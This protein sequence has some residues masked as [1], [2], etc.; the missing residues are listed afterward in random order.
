MYRKIIK[1]IKAQPRWRLIVAGLALAG[2]VVFLSRGSKA[3]ADMATFE[4]RR[5]ALQISVLEGGTLQ[6]LSS[7]E[8]K[9]EVRVGYQGTKIL[10][11]VDEGY[12]VTEEDV[13]NAKILVELDSSELQKQIVQQEIQYQSAVANLTDSQQGYEIQLNQNQ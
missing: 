2:A 8:L 13:K 4:A 11:I 6:A 12:M 9:C 3:T 1:V 5:G 7:Q 10:K